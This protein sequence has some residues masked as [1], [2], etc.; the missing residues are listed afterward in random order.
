MILNFEKV[1]WNELLLFPV[2]LKVNCLQLKIM[3]FQHLNWNTHLQSL[4]HKLSKVSF[5]IKTLKETLSPYM[6]RHIYF[7]K[8][9]AILHSGIR[10]WGGI[11]GDSSIRVFKIQKRVVRLLAGVSLRTSCRQLFKKLNIL[12]MASLYILEVTCFI[13]KNCKFLEQNSQVHQHDTRRKLDIQV[14][15]KSTEIYKKSIINMGTKVY[16]KLPRFL[17]EIEEYGT[18]RKKLKLFLLLHSFYSVEEF[19]SF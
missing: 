3:P 7:T 16:N 19:I 15:M 5:M 9:Q 13:R 10:L 1:H 11:K 8:F 2:P 6:I 14:K 4:A 18:F 12:T 17:K